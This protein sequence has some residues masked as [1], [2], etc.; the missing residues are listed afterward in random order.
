[1]TVQEKFCERVLHLLS[2]FLDLRIWFVAEMYYEN[3]VRR[4]PSRDDKKVTSGLVRLSSGQKIQ[5]NAKSSEFGPRSQWPNSDFMTVFSPNALG[6]R[7]LYLS[8]LDYLI[9]SWPHKARPCGYLPLGDHEI[10]DI[11]VTLVL[12]ITSVPVHIGL[13]LWPRSSVPKS[14]FRPQKESQL[15]NVGLA[16]I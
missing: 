3:T 14:G 15:K 10:R 4:M 6:T 9:C 12:P 7:E 5:H 11:M 1:M 16:H 13:A 2:P 8:P